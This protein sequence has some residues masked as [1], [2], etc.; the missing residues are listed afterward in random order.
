MKQLKLKKATE[1]KIPITDLFRGTKVNA[2]R[3]TQLILM[4]L[5]ILIIN[6]FDYYSSNIEYHI[7]IM[8]K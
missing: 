2:D 4:L 5:F 6:W 3:N 7:I 1:E 8:N